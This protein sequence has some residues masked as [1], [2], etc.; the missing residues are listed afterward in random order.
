MSDHI[1]IQRLVGL[2]LCSVTVSSNSIRLQLAGY[3]LGRSGQFRDAA[4]IEI[5]HAYE[6]TSAQ[7]SV[8]VTQE[9]GLESFR[10]ESSGFLQL[11]EK[12]IDNASFGTQGELKLVFSEGTNV[13]LLRSDEGFESFHIHHG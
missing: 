6:I 10:Q 5:E 12:S 1:E 9:D 2:E 13:R 4:V 3:P 7:G 8:S 11:I